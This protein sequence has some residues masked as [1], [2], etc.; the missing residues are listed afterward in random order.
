LVTARGSRTGTLRVTIALWHGRHVTVPPRLPL[1]TD[2]L[3]LRPYTPDD[4]DATLAYYGDPHVSRFLLSEPF[5]IDDATEVVNKRQGQTHPINAGDSLALVVEHD[6]TLVGD[7][8][9]K[10][11]GEKSSIGEI[12]W[13]FDPSFSG[14]GFAT[15]AAAALLDL[16]FEHYGMHRVMAQMDARNTSSARLCERLGMTKEAHLRQDWWS[17][18]EWTDTYVYA[19]LA[20]EWESRQLSPD[21]RSS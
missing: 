10:F 2:R 1:H 12:G 9:L 5:T 21:F 3:L 17:K 4:V 8:M 6:T 19:M 7:L 18:G 20:P 14:R 11:V 13:C 15:E 16:A